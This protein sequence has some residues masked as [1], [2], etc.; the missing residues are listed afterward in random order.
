M[1]E[2]MFIVDVFVWIGISIGAVALIAIVHEIWGRRR[3]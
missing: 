3:K 2:Q 1:F